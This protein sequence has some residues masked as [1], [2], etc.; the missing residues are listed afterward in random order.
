MSHTHAFALIPG[1]TPAKEIRE[2]LWEMTSR[3][4]EHYTSECIEPCHCVGDIAAEQVCI[5]AYGAAIGEYYES[6]NQNSCKSED[7]DSCSDEDLVR[8]SKKVN[9]LLAVHS[10]ALTPDHKCP[11]C[12]GVGVVVHYYDNY[13]FYRAIYIGG[14]YNGLIYG[15]DRD[16]ASLK[17]KEMFKDF[18]DDAIRENCRPVCEIPIEDPFYYADII[19]TPDGQLDRFEGQS[20]WGE[21]L[22]AEESK[23][24]QHI[25]EVF[26]QH[27]DHLVVD[28]DFRM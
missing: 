10:L 13:S 20:S 25:V 11:Y 19:V 6:K 3:Y 1:D 21:E 27:S 16:Y 22:N 8:I 14:A 26:K 18:D 17:N 5:E 4:A 12:K 15:K 28:L 7:D 9:E 24:H 2:K 23:W